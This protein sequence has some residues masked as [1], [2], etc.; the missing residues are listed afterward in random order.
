MSKE[1]QQ[2]LIAVIRRHTRSATASS[3]GPEQEA[4]AIISTTLETMRDVVADALRLAALVEASPR[5]QAALTADPSSA[6]AG[7]LQAGDVQDA[8]A[9][10]RSFGVWLAMPVDVGGAREVTP[11]SL[12]QRRENVYSGEEKMAG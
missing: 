3:G 7:Q 4:A 8:V 1:L 2:E 12:I 10:W 5:V 6:F 9:V 11:Q